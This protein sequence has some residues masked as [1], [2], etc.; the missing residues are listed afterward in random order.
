MSITTAGNAVTEEVEHSLEL[1]AEEGAKLIKTQL[2]VDMA[3]LETIAQRDEIIT[4]DWEIQQSV[5]SG[6][7]DRQSFNALGV[8]NLDG[9]GSYS[10]G[11][12]LDL[13]G[14]NYVEAALKG[15][16]TVSN[17]VIDPVTNGPV[18]MLTT[19]IK[20]SG[21]VVG[22]LIGR[23]NVFFLSNLIT[24]MGFGDQGYAYIIDEQ[25]T[26]ISDADINRVINQWNPII[27]AEEDEE[28]KSVAENFQKIIEE[29]NG[30]STYIYG[31]N[32]LYCG[33][34][35]IEETDWTI[36]ITATRDEV[37]DALPSLQRNIIIVTL[38]VLIVSIIVC[39]VVG[40]SIAKPIILTA[41]HAEKIANL[42][43][44]Q[45]ISKKLLQRKDEIGS[46]SRAFQTITD[47]LRSFINQ[48]ADTSQQ[49]ASSSQQLTATSQ[50]SA[51][52]A[53]EV[54]RTI[55]EIA[56]SANEQ[57]KDT[58]SGVLKTDE[59][60]KIIEKDV[61]H[62]EQINEAM[63]QL[64]ILKDQGVEIIKALTDKTHRSHEA[65]QA[66]YEST[67]ETNG[68]AEK[69]GEASRLIE[70]IAEQTNL[71]ALNAAIE[72]ARAGEAGK[73]FA[74]VAEEIRKLAEQ[75]THSAKEID[76][77]V[78]KLQS[79]S[80]STVTT[81][82]EVSSFIKEQV[83]SVDMTESKFE[84]ISNQVESVTNIVN[85]SLMAVEEMVIKKDELADVIQNLAAIA[86]ENAAGTEE[87]SASVE[88]QTASMEE[89]ANSS[90]SLARLA[91]EMQDSIGKFKY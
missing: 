11:I 40:N 47:N 38:M 59:L 83:T 89:I 87:A 56:K 64:I 5:L 30:T 54:A 46:L 31:G 2:R 62:M 26:I 9:T 42:D 3:I 88:E 19:P 43:I 25:G 72:A 74:V 60:N 75:S 48:I 12:P 76:D 68:N 73:G 82:Q 39:W 81:M 91:E 50:Q 28:L 20:N 33:F 27:E 61:R 71:L 13:R 6:E 45:D 85:Q 4:M 36:V 34:A 63:K 22:A 86:E 66:I 32:D 51:M 24:D 78:R 17:V 90:D 67:V 23:M 44:T 41:K 57:A 58:E 52:A 1:L 70:S 14:R 69:I 79:T 49:V 7:L 35:P 37:L 53:D 65:A 80:Q 55:E 18:V 29:K 16:T 21:I 8:I 10:N 84:G 15:K 77:M